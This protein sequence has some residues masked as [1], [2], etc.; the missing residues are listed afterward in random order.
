VSQKT[1]D[2]IFDDKLLTRIVRL[3]QFFAHLLPR[4]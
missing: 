3:Q 1:C 2:Y 4:V